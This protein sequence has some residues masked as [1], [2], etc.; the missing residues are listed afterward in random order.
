VTRAV[1]PPIVIVMGVTG[2]G[3]TTIGR[4]VA[5]ELGVTFVDG[6][7]F[8][9][10]ANIE[11]MQR[12]EPLDDA[13]R[14]PWLDRLNAE[15]RKHTSDGVVLACSALKQSYRDRLTNGLP[16]GAD[17]ARFVLLTTAPGLLRRRIEART[18]HFAHADLLPSQL[19][20]LEPPRNAL[21]VDVSA[22][23]DD[24]VAEVLTGLARPS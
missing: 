23:P 24:V 13:A 12:G 21:V 5:K 17:R 18:D 15:L 9:D 8:H 19:A 7:D 3:K 1:T 6:D 11:R 2:S 14:R 20:A 16:D 22:P 4:M 10:P